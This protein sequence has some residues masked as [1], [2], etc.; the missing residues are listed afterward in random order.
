VAKRDPWWPI[1]YGHEC[2]LTFTEH[3]RILLPSGIEVFAARNGRNAATPFAIA[4]MRE[5]GL[6]IG[7]YS[8]VIPCDDALELRAKLLALAYPEG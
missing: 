2:G 3:K 1:E 7:R 4:V 8:E 6:D 5:P